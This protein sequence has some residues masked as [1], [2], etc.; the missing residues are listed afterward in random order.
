[1]TQFDSSILQPR[2]LPP[3]AALRAFEAAARH[4]S[5]RLAAAELGVTPTAISHQIRLLEE[6]LG[7]A[8]FIRRARG[9]A[10]TD[11]GRRLFP[12]LRDGFDMFDRAIRELSPRRR[13][14][15]TLSAT[16]LFTVRRILPAIG[17]FRERFPDYDLRLHASDDPV[18]LVAGEAD[19]A[20]RY[21]S[22]RYRG[23]VATPLLAERFGVLCSPK[24]GIA[25]PEDLRGMTLLHIE[26]RRAGRA[27]DWRL[28]ARLAGIEG[29]SVDQGPRFTEDDHALQAAAAGS[30]VALSGL[31]L[32]RPAI[33]AGLLVHPFGPVIE[34]EFYHAVTTPERRDDPAV[35]AVCD[36]LQEDV[37]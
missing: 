12:T 3:L 18:D 10:L 25:R 33:D 30:G 37:V 13:A 7:L 2:R 11:A 23:L 17:G 20:V 29:L 34:G 9:V 8:L 32:A 22:G 27:P 14:A 1:M 28:W 15:V 16:T 19:V 26:W 5:F 24:A 6:T 4:V 36:W 21:G 31:A 35:R